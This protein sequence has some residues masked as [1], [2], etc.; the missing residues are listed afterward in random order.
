MVKKIKKGLKKKFFE[1]SV[2]LIS[3]KMHVYGYSPE[4]FN[5]KTIKIDMTRSLRG[6]GL[7]LKVRIASENEKLQGALQNLNLFQSY[8]RRIIRKGTDYV[9]D[10]F[11]V[12]SREHILRIKP[13]LITRKRVSRAIRKAIRESTRKYL[14]G[15]TKVMATKEIF[16]DIIT[17]KIQRDIAQKVKKIYPLALCEIRQLNVVSALK[18]NK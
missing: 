5:G 11:E 16:S 14:E 9:E 7:E 1:V 12:E 17:N 10:S 2:P 6:K 4:D 8:I 13:F 3:T 18:K 15:K